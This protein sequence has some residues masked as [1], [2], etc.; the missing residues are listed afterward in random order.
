M[1]GSGWIHP[2]FYS[3]SCIN[4]IL[5]FSD[6]FL[7]TFVYLVSE[8]PMNTYYVWSNYINIELSNDPFIKSCVLCPLFLFAILLSLWFNSYH[9]MVNLLLSLFLFSWLREWW[10]VM[11]GCGFYC[12]AFALHQLI[13]EPSLWEWWWF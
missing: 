5:V 9:W 12:F 1:Q 3:I 10:V 8:M 2:E 13:S 7:S 6:S 11:S 4:G